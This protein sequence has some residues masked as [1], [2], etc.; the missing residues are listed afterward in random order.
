M[1]KLTD[2]ELEVDEAL[3][4]LRGPEGVTLRGLKNLAEKCGVVKA[5][6]VLPDSDCYV[7]IDFRSTPE[8]ER[9]AVLDWLGGEYYTQVEGTKEKAVLRETLDKLHRAWEIQPKKKA[10]TS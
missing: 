5:Q 1:I 8:E 7:M 2:A 9:E 4:A 10:T 3:L 6:S